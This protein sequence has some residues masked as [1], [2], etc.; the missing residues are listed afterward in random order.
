M[1]KALAGADDVRGSASRDARSVE[2]WRAMPVYRYRAVSPAGEVAVGELEAANEAEIVEPPAR[3]G[4]DADA[5]RACHRRRVGRAPRGARAKRGQAT[6]RMF[7][8]KTVTRDQL[9]ALTRELATLLQAGLP[10]DRALEI[11]IG[12]APTPPVAALLQG[13][14]DDVR[15]GKALS[16][17]L[18]A[19]R[20]DLLALL[21]QH[22][23][24]GRGGRRARAWCCSVWPT[25][26]SA[27]RSCA[28][29][30]KSR[31]H[32]SD[33]PGLRRGGLG[34]VAARSGWCRSSRP[35]SRRR[36]RRCR[37]PR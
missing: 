33:D 10:L 25:R 9:L 21:R 17:A 24:R 22:R 37:S 2:R 30:V 7:E 8:S 26:W 13:V 1:R 6:A 35:R 19:R 27:T 12:L 29:R 32:L 11:L 3:P 23:A 18:D 16:Q 5:D 15:G 28:S 36:A 14:R 4:P 31:A 34:R 20:D